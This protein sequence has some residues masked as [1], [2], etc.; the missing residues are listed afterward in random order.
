MATTATNLDNIK[1]NYPSMLDRYDNRTGDYG[2]LKKANENANSSMGIIT[3]DLKMK[4]ANSWG[5]TIDIPVMSPTAGGIASGL[6]CTPTD[7]VAISAFMNVTW[8]SVSASWFMEPSLNEQNEISYLEMWL[9]QYKANLNAIYDS[10][11]ASIDTALTAALAVEAEYSNSMIGVGTKYGTLTADRI[12][13]SL[14]QRELFLN[15]MTSINKS[16]DIFGR[17]DLIGSTNAESILRNTFG[18]GQSNDTNTAFQAGLFDATF[19]NN[20]TVG[21]ASDASCYVV[22]KGSFGI[23]YRNHP[24]CAAGRSTTS[25]KQ[26]STVFDPVFGTDLDVTFQ[27]VCADINAKTGN[28]LDVANVQ[29]L[30]QIN[31]NFGIITPSNSFGDPGSVAK[32]GVIRAFN[33]QTA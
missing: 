33:F 7:D 13:V 11:D 30:H 23:V 32:G 18:Q 16:D 22:P 4:A 1:V 10:V 5:R 9:N 3:N 26:Y 14:A 31:V 29:E 25:G 8:V 28:A 24:D 12:D 15:D 17:Q 27:S 6:V 20:V 19:T 21:A 2:L